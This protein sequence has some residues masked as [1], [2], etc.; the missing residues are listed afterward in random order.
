MTNRMVLLK[1]HI[2]SQPENFTA[3]SIPKPK[4]RNLHRK[5]EAIEKP[6]SRGDNISKPFK[7]KKKLNKRKF[8]TKKEPKPLLKRPITPKYSKQEITEA[9]ITGAFRKPN[10]NSGGDKSWLTDCFEQV[11]TDITTK[12]IGNLIW[13]YISHEHGNVVLNTADKFYEQSSY[14]SNT[15]NPFQ[16]NAKK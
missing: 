6:T 14:T 4:N 15:K 3:K 5:R 10:H 7:I 16:Q 8:E 12:R 11:Y 1:S 9:C 2:L 13:Q